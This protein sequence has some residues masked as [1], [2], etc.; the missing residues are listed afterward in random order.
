MED[1]YLIRTPGAPVGVPRMADEEI[2]DGLLAAGA[3]VMK[4]CYCGGRFERVDDIV[5]D[6]VVDGERVVVKHL[7]ELRCIR[8]GMA[9]LSPGSMRMV[10]RRARRKH[11]RIPDL[12]I[13]CEWLV[14]AGY[15]FDRWFS[16]INTRTDPM[17]C[18]CLWKAQSGSPVEYRGFACLHHHNPS[19]IFHLT[20][21]FFDHVRTANVL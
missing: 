16:R 14:D 2:G 21:R 9:A 8:C 6:T 12:N 3:V 17:T 7:H 18:S 4:G 11:D 1:E 19:A 5:V 13:R 20:K 15:W 10:E